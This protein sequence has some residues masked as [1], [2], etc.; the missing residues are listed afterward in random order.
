[1]ATSVWQRFARVDMV[2]Q[3]NPPLICNSAEDSSSVLCQANRPTSSPLSQNR[4]WWLSTC[5]SGIRR[6]LCSDSEAM[7][8]VDDTAA[9]KDELS[10]IAS[11][12]HG[13]PPFKSRR[14]MIRLT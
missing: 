6:M 13:L 1:M 2:L 4:V 7:I 8:G 9:Y 12:K 10:A 3:K 11:V 5:G 14:D